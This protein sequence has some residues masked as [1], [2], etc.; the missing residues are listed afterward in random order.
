MN[1][2]AKSLMNSRASGSGMHSK[3]ATNAAN[4]ASIDEEFSAFFDQGD[5]GHYVGGLSEPPL[6]VDP[7]TYDEPKEGHV[8]V[9]PTARRAFFAKVVTVVVAG[10]ATLM[11]VAVGVK[12]LP[13]HAHARQV[14]RVAEVARE[15][16]TLAIATANK[17]TGAVTAEVRSELPPA[18]QQTQPIA[19]PGVADAPQFAAAPAVQAPTI[20]APVA[21]QSPAPIAAKGTKS[22]N[23][24][25]VTPSTS[26]NP[27]PKV[28]KPIRDVQSV[29]ARAIAKNRHLNQVSTKKSAGV[30]SLTSVVGSKPSV[31]AFPLD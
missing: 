19:K 16:P 9:K 13:S 5:A 24:E 11:V 22:E 7:V 17:E 15:R 28:V 29:T 4:T 8:E 31:V 10:C 25:K 3:V 2:T 1:D 6:S 21:A 23:P 26:D 20:L 18:A 12:S 27:S 30:A 14:A